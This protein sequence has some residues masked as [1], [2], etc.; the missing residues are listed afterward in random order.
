MSLEYWLSPP[1]F[2][3]ET[4][5][6]VPQTP[7]RWK[8]NRNQ[9]LL[10]NSSKERIA[11]LLVSP[12]IGVTAYYAKRLH[13]SLF[14]FIITGRSLAYKTPIHW[15]LLE[16]YSAPTSYIYRTYSIGKRGH[17]FFVWKLPKIKELLWIGLLLNV[18]C[19]KLSYDISAFCLIISCL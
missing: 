9:D 14:C 17:L 15:S 19:I 11:N 12:D 6:N 1:L 7:D 8:L 10:P 4:C 2:H 16:L 13:F 18:I 5:E 3:L